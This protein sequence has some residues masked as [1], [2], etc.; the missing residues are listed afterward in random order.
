MCTVFGLGAV[1]VERGRVSGDERIGFGLYQSSPGTR[2]SVGTCV[3]V[4]VAVRVA[5]CRLRVG[6]GTWTG[7]VSG[8]VVLCLCEV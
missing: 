2:G 6:R 8:G 5:W 1:W 4:L 3:C 7:V